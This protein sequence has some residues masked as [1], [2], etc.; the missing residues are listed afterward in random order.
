MELAPGFLQIPD[1]DRR[2]IDDALASLPNIRGKLSVTFEFN[3]PAP[4]VV[5]ALKI[6]KNIEVLLRR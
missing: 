6:Y 2:A 1:A 4:G 3:C 5:G